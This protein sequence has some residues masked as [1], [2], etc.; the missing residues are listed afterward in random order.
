MMNMSVE[1]DDWV[2][3]HA[4]LASAVPRHHCA[5]HGMQVQY[6]H[7]LP[8]LPKPDLMKMLLLCAR[9]PGLGDELT[10]VMAWARVLSHQAAGQFTRSDFESICEDL[11]SKVVCYGLVPQSD[12][13]LTC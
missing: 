6:G 9:L 8:D 5:E 11:R 10:P 12:F 1:K 3:G 4:L 2:S 7:K 13:K